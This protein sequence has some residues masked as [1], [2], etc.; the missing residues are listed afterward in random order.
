MVKDVTFHLFRLNL[1]LCA[2]QDIANLVQPERQSREFW[3]RQLFAKRTEFRFRETEYVFIPYKSVS[4]KNSIVGKIGRQISSIEHTPPEDGYEEIIHDAWKAAIV[5]VD[6]TEHADGQ[7]VA[8]EKN[9]DVGSPRTLAKQLLRAMEASNQ[10]SPFLTSIHSITNREAF[11]NFAERN[12]GKITSLTFDLEVP[13]MFGS[14][15]EY[16]RE[17]KEYRDKEKAKNVQIKISNP[18]GIS[19]DT[20]RVRYTVDKASRGTGSVSAKAL[21]ESYSSDEQ[22]VTS[23]ITAEETS[24]SSSLL[25]LASNL[26]SRIFG[27]E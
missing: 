23:S 21:G 18:N 13:N 19:V 12:E 20:D 3:I 17:M 6:P 8:I 9:T 22:Q 10:P 16:G 15:D 4:S 11:W 1:R 26:A 5:V 2:Q 27:R 14:D 25:S 24:G 7:K